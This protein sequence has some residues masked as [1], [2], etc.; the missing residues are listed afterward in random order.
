MEAVDEADHSQEASR[1]LV[2][3]LRSARVG[4][5]E[6]KREMSEETWVEQRL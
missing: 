5:R 2:C 4:L 1:F 3:F 6:G